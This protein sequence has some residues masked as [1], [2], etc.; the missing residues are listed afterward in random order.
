MKKILKIAAIVLV[1]LLIAVFA[2]P[3]LY[4]DKIV[5]YIKEDIN[6]NL[7][8]KVDFK[9]VDLSLFKS[10]PNFNLGI[11]NLSVDG[12]ETFKNVRLLQSKQFDLVLDI[13]SVLKG[14]Q[15]KIN[16]I[17]VDN[18]EVNIL[19]NK[20][21][22]AN[23]DITKP[24]DNQSEPSKFNIDLK[25]YILKN[26][27]IIYDDQSM[28]FKADI[29]H[30]NHEGSGKLSDKIYELKTKSTADSL[31]ITYGNIDYLHN[32]KTEINT[33][34]DI[35]GNFSKYTL[36]NT[37]AIINELPLNAEGFVE[38]KEKEIVMDIKYEAEKADIIKLLSLVPK[39]YMPDLNG[40]K[41][42]GVAK[43]SGYVKG[44]STDTDLPGFK[45]LVDVQNASIQYPDLPEK[46][47]NINLLT[48]VD[49]KGGS[50]LN[51]M[52]VDLPRI[53]FDIAGSHVSGNLNVKQPMTDPFIAAGFQSKLDFAKVKKAVKFEQ[54]KDLSGLLDA[55]ISFS[56]PVS[57]MANQ[58][59]EKINAKGF[60]N[61]TNFKMKSDAYKDDIQISSAKMNLTPASLQ[62]EQFNALLGKNDLSLTGK[63]NNY[64]GY[65][66]GKN[67]ILKGE[68]SAQSKLL[69]LN[70]FMTSNSTDNS[71]KK[72]ESSSETGVMKVPKN[73]DVT[74]NLAAEQVKYQN[75]DLKNVK[76]KLS[77]ANQ[78]VKL[79]DVVM[80]MLGGTVSMSGLY[81]TQSAEPK[82]NFSL[83]VKQLNIKESASSFTVL[84]SYAPILNQLTGDFFSDLNL[85]LDLNEKMQP[86]LSSVSA[87][88]LFK[89]NEVSANGV[90]ILSKV[91][92]LLKINALKNPKIE[93]LNANFAIQNGILTL[94]PNQ[95]KINGMSAGISGTFNLDK[96]IDLVLSLDVPKE[97]LGNN[98][99]SVLTNLAGV[100]Q[101]L[102]LGKVG[103]TV[104]T[105]FKITG[106]ALNPKI[107]PI[108][109][110][111]EGQTLTETVKE[112]VETKITE[113]KNEALDKAQAEADKLIAAATAQKE[114]FVQEAEKLAQE[115]R[116]K[117][118]LGADELL[119]QAGA[120]PLKKLAAQKAADKIVQEG[121]KKAN[122]LLDVAKKKGDDLVL[123]AQEQGNTL[124]E[125]ARNKGNK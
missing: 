1:L 32:V 124:I 74:M 13:K 91:A 41:S 105:K 8:A 76:G 60:F 107:K 70:D 6:K 28:G 48:D 65:V 44:H 81:N 116:D 10:F 21:G 49:F 104:K 82:T 22:K 23:Y 55:D 88:G 89:T 33:D 16:K 36:K 64:L 79:S 93:N 86:I 3:Y 34:F 4:K 94:K 66:L 83:G 43:V 35:S 57:A 67:D 113:V 5:N 61:L 9:D 56:G 110:G 92:D 68:F 98:L 99:N 120:N 53:N 11:N 27:H 25:N 50:D 119:K 84:N 51:T 45:L 78:E 97:K 14:E 40:A 115:T 2:I 102:D 125:S 71:A 37:K 42:T 122:Q 80:N 18:A 123:K 118:K 47:S 52:T 96:Q 121:D 103:E 17:F 95:F 106:N 85:S 54:I 77:I 12:V 75:L 101:K 46:V 20:D 15:I 19:V 39:A 59:V 72:V 109:L 62:I 117:A 69:N 30:L 24:S 38:M 31:T 7:N 100:A 90:N 87:S 63:L 108:L 29:K 58:Q 26:A 112:V 73:I 111:S 114:K